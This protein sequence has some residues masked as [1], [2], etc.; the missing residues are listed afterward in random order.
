MFLS[1]AEAAIRLKI[2][3]RRVRALLEDGRI[4][5]ERVSGRWVIAESDVSKYQ[6]GGLAGRPLSEKSAWQLA[7]QAWVDAS[8]RAPAPELSAVEKYRANQRLARLKDAPDPL[9]LIRSWLVNRAEKVEFSSSPSDLGQ[10][11]DDQRIRLSGVSHPDSGLLANSE[12]E[13]YVC[14]KDFDSLIRDW[15]LVKAAAGQRPNVVLH[16]A[17]EIPEKLPP[18]LVAADLAERAGVREQNA[19]R[20]IIRSI[21]AG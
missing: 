7:L 20:D 19:A 6:P 8:R 14:R 4:P 9:A 18:L 16:V 1:P 3:E 13:A 21:H 11:R 5:A 17:D 2:S 15:F 10:M 12:L